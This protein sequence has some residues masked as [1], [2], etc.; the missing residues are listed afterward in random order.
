MESIQVFCGINSVGVP[1]TRDNRKHISYFDII[2]NDLKKDYNVSGYNISS[3]SKNCTWDFDK[4]LNENMSLLQIRNLQIYGYN[5]LRDANFLFK[6]VVPKN[7]QEVM[8]FSNDPDVGFKTLIEQSEN[9]IFLYNGGQNDF[10][11]FIQAGPV[12]LLN[13]KVRDNLPDDLENL[14]FQCAD[15]VVKNWLSLYDINQNIKIFSY[16]FYY[17]PLFSKINNVIKFQN[18]LKKKNMRYEDG[19]KYLINLYNKIL[20][21]RADDYDFVYY[22]PLDFIEDYCST[23]DFHPNTRGNELIAELSLN[24]INNEILKSKNVGRV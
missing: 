3:L 15:N 5:K 17:S 7:F 21:E 18:F 24:V 16:G 23:M 19:F 12:E 20:S 4:I 1:F 13:R 2:V 9:P 14:I 11:T 22:V 10:F 6:L 8:R